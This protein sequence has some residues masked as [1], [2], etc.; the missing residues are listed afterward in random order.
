VALCQLA[1]IKD[2]HAIEVP[3]PGEDDTLMVIRLGKQA[4]AYK[5]ICP[6]AGRALNWAPGRFLIEHGMVVCAAHGAAFAL[7]SGLCIGGPCRGQ[8]LTSVPV[9]VNFGAVELLEK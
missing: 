8:S 7:E 4:V 6:H 3:L 2:G 5:N 1:D 9:H